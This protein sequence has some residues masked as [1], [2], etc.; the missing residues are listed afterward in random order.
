LLG[1]EDIFAAQVRPIGSAINPGLFGSGFA[2]RLSRAEARAAGGELLREDT[3]LV[4]TLPRWQGS[5]SAQRSSP[6]R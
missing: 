3:A 2:L 6:I 1:E 5:E 4:L